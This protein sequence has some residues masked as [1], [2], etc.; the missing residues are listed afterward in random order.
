[1][2]DY[3]RVARWIPHAFDPFVNLVD[4]IE[5]GI[6]AQQE[7]GN[8]DSE[9]DEMYVS[10]L[11]RSCTTDFAFRTLQRQERASIPPQD[12]SRICESRP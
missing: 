1:M 7:G 12:H 9:D 11:A 8:V 4:V 6:A 2:D 3:I 10:R 5:T